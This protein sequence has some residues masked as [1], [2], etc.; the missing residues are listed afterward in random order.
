MVASVY[1]F[2]KTMINAF[3]GATALDDY[4]INYMSDDIAV[5]LCTSL[6]SPDLDADM[7]WSDVDNEVVGGNYPAGGVVLTGKSL[8]YD[9]PNNQTKFKAGNIVIPNSTI[10]ARYAVI[11]DKTPVA[12][13]DKCLLGYIDFGEDKI[14]DADDFTINWHSDGILRGI[15]E[16]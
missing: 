2:G 3:G 7:F 13:E 10:T 1:W 16:E 14:S 9:S 5:A 4:R 6:Y 15:V 8:E 12:D 11:Y